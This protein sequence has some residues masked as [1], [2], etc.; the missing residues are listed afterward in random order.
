M[1]RPG[2]AGGRIFPRLPAHVHR[3]HRLIR[4]SAGPLGRG[5][6]NRYRSYWCVDAVEP[7][8]LARDDDGVAVDHPGGPGQGGPLLREWIT[9]SATKKLGKAQHLTCV[10]EGR[11]QYGVLFERRVVSVKVSLRS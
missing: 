7:N 11:C 4:A 5:L 8:M 1:D 3:R 10:N 6:I 2:Q 9:R